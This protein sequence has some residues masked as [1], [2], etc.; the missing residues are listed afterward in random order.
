MYFADEPEHIAML[1][2][3]LRRFTEQECPREKRQE[4]LA[5][6]AWPRD[7][8]AKLAALGVCGLTVEEEYGGQ[9][10]DW[11]AATAVIEELGRGGVCLAD[12]I[13]NAPFT[14]AVISPKAARR[15]RRLNCCPKLPAASCSSP[16]ACRSPIPAVIWPTSRLRRIWRTV[17]ILWSSTASNAG[18]RAPI[19]P[20]IFFAS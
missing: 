6:H 3:T 2:D 20:T 14:A 12:L 4:W 18:A 8:F 16:M 19:G 10:Q 1:R 7:V 13:F 9:G 11:Y 5:A 17:G 15:R